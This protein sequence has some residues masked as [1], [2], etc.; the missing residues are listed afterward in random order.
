M[1]V[2]VNFQP[3]IPAARRQSLDLRQLEE[4]LKRILAYVKQ[5]QDP[6]LDNKVGFQPKV[7]GKTRWFNVPWM[8]YDP[9]AGREFV[10]GTTNERTA[11]LDDLINP[12][13][14]KLRTAQTAHAANYLAGMSDECKEQ[15]PCRL[16]NL[17]GRLL[18]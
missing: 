7:G 15:V 16:R 10:H 3:E 4:Y 17:G 14:K 1:Q 5:G 18:Q 6:Q 13:N 12:V 2:D 8:A 11:H 9:T